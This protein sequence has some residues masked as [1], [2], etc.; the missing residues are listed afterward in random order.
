MKLPLL[1]HFVNVLNESMWAVGSMNWKRREN[2]MS[3]EYLICIQME[4]GQ[5]K[6]LRNLERLLRDLT[7]ESREN[8]CSSCEYRYNCRPFPA[9]YSGG[10]SYYA[11]DQNVG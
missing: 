1:F 6:I 11:K 7:V 10:C 3:G 4:E 8:L 5:D 9:D 2:H